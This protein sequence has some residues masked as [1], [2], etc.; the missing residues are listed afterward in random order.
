[1]PTFSPAR[2]ER[3]RRS[4]A[5]NGN[6]FTNRLPS[7]LVSASNVKLL[8]RWLFER[9]DREPPAP[10]PSV[11]VDPRVLDGP[12][13]DGLR[14]TWLGHSTAL[15]EIGGRRVLIDPVWSER[16]SPL[17]W[18]GPRR[19]QPVPVALERIPLPDAVI[20][21]HDHDDHLDH[22]TIVA[23]ARRGARFVTALGVGARLEG[24]GIDAAQVTE[25]DW[26]Q[27]E[28]PVA[29]LRIRAL[30][31]RHFSGRS[32]GDRNRT[33]WASW[34]IE[35]G[36][37]HLY[38][39]GDGGLDE[40]MFADIGQRLGPFDLTLLE[41]GAFDPA[42]GT[43][44][45][46][47]ENALVAHRLL[48]GR[49]LL[50]VHWGTF[51]LGLHAWDA[52]VE[53]LLAAAATT[54]VRIALPRLGES[55]VAGERLPFEPWWRVLRDGKRAAQ[56]QSAKPVEPIDDAASGSRPQVAMPID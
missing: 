31:A 22:A 45:L 49:A 24:W 52:P 15:I 43:I 36:G 16:A 14:V 23:L 8:G 41:I 44:H 5:W 38:F 12:A 42:W 54:D 25:L 56:P 39:G 35:A 18:S 28:S 4:P 13:A 11:P 50:P 17:T 10:L 34:S 37:A 48:R 26:W 29:G 7:P 53:E 21:S 47:P 3:F 46:G 1:M 2:L 27:E 9:A 33:L 30:P 51:N 55:V 20:V 32:V 40:E 19:F 6:G